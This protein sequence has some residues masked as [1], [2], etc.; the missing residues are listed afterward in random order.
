MNDDE[1]LN[2]MKVLLKPEIEFNIQKAFKKV[3][4]NILQKI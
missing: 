4:E 2:D 1:F 3:K